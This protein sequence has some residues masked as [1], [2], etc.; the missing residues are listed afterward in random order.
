MKR[1]KAHRKLMY[2]L[3]MSIYNFYQMINIKL[4]YL[5]NFLKIFKLFL[6]LMEQNS[7]LAS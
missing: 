4:N 1:Q 2:D 7:N 3:F 6:L 5:S